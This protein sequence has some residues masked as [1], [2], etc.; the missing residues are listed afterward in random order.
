[1]VARQ[2]TCGDLECKR[3]NHAE[4]C[5][6]WRQKN[7]D[8]SSH[9][10]SDVIAPF[11]VRH[12][13]YQREWRFVRSLRKI[14]GS[15]DPIVRAVD[16]PLDRL[17]SR[18]ERVLMARAQECT[19]RPPHRRDLFSDVLAVAQ[20][21]S[22]AVKELSSLTRRL[23]ELDACSNGRGTT[24]VEAGLA[25]R[26]QRAAP[27]RTGAQLVEYTTFARRAGHGR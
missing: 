5:R 23:A 19:G 12:Q 21:L 6:R 9:H 22:R 26:R 17:V 7:Q 14:R 24:A 27:E 25:T 10:Y 15:I 13:T 16:G 3:R 4:S 8:A 20:R 1:V 11:R 18:G 2:V